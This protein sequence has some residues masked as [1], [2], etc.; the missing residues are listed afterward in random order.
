MRRDG[1][2]P[3]RGRKGRAALEVEEGADRWAP[4]VGDRVRE[5]EGSGALGRV[6][7]KWNWAASGCLDRFLLF[8]FSFQILFNTN[9][10]HILNSNLHTNFHNFSQLF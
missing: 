9:L 3:A 1:R 10:L 7:R 4:P 8:F 5:R 2:R 6:G